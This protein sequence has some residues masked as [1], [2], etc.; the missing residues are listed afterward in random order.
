M[1]LPGISLAS[2]VQQARSKQKTLLKAYG[3]VVG[4]R[5][6]AARKTHVKIVKLLLERGADKDLRDND[7]DG[8]DYYVNAAKH[9]QE[10][11]RA[12]LARY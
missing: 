4:S 8:V 5:D 2:F 10:E 1:C 11:L 12:L 3:I 7:G 6:V 9:S